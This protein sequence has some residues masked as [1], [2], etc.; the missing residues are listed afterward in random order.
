MPFQS[1][2][3]AAEPETE[4]LGDESTANTMYPAGQAEGAN[5]TGPAPPQSAPVAVRRQ[6][7]V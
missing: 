2:Y 5:K 3:L 7:D 4:P 1:D 6:F